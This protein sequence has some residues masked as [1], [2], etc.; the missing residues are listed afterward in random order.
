MLTL[1]AHRN[2][3]FQSSPSISAI[4]DFIQ[5]PDTLIWLDALD[6]GDD[7]MKL[8]SEEFC[9]HPLA[10]DDYFTPHFRPKVVEF[11]SYCFI[12]TH[13][14]QSS[15]DD[16]TVVTE[17]LD[18][19][20]GKNYIVTLHEKPLSV[21]EHVSNLWR[22]EPRMLGGGAGLL[23]YDIMDAVVDSYFPILD[24]IEEELDE[25]ENTIFSGSMD[26][27]SEHIF[28]LKRKLLIMHRVAA[29]LRDIF[30]SITRREQEIFTEQAVT[31]LRDIY[32][33]TLRIVDTIDT[34]RDMITSSLDAYF[35]VISNQMN[36]IMKTLTVAATILM[37]IQI[38]TGIYGMNL[39]IPETR[40][41][42]GYPFALGLMA[43]LSGVMLYYFKKIKWL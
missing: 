6:P 16:K 2:D 7:E 19:F 11:D 40:W 18:M 8:L 14:V 1:Y 20:V 36:S 26:Q 24:K 32:D 5:E 34:Y 4:S 9:F 35:T 3:V 42:Y 38:V 33:H 13:V 39:K 43:L 10:I 12:V 37:T 29:P 15:D 28:R 22:K 41:E 25:I 17:E 23:L 27:S 21:L 31:Y 30:N